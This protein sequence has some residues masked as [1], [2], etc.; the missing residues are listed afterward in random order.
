M[1]SIA[2]GF[3]NSVPLSVKITLNNNLKFSTP[4]LLQMV[5][6]AFVTLILSFY[7]ISMQVG[8]EILQNE[9]LIKPLKNLLYQWLY[10]F[11]Q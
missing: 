2:E 5:F 3:E 1:I 10:P 8:N 6:K 7:L 4:I 11:E 9:A